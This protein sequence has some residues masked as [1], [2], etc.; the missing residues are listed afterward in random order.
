[1]DGLSLYNKA[2]VGLKEDARFGV[3]RGPKAKTFM[4]KALE[5][6]NN[7]NWGKIRTAIPDSSGKAR[8]LTKTYQH[9]TL[10][11][12]NNDALITCT[13]SSDSVSID[14]GLS[15]PINYE[16]IQQIIFSAMM[17]KLIMNSITPEGLNHI[18]LDEKH[19]RYNYDDGATED[20]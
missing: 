20:N 12:V 8:Y 15:V 18:E 3:C 5:A 6:C 17:T 7:F 10:K 13:R 9:L 1:M 4:R 14:E 19:V 2:T 11:E 16:I